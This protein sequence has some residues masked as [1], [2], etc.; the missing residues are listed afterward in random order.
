[1]DQQTDIAIDEV[2]TG[3]ALLRPE[4][5]SL[6]S[7]AH[8]T[9]AKAE[10]VLDRYIAFI[11]SRTFV[12][13]C[14]HRAMQAAFSLPVVTYSTLWELQGQ[15]SNSVALFLLSLTDARQAECANALKALSALDPSIPIVVLATT[16]DM[17]LVRTAINYGAKGYIPYSTKFEIAME[18]VRFILAGGTYVPTDY[19]L[20]S[21]QPSFSASQASQLSSVLTAREV[22]VVQAIQEGKS[23]KVIAY[24]LGICEGTVKV[25]LR[26]VMKKLKAKNRTEVAIKAQT[27][28]RPN[29]AGVSFGI[30]KTRLNHL[31]WPSGGC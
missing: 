15:F 22:N 8:H 26:N 21:A 25:H 31:R 17:D 30:T 16:N 19:L 29:N 2:R 5:E 4:R 14:M 13:E 28:L 20:T 11:E 24:Q 18:A 6:D 23:N 12:R 27:A 1:M 3:T 9:Y 7:N 10:A